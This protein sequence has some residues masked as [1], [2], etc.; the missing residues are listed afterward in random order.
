MD[1]SIEKS[2]E[3]RITK[4]FDLNL[5]YS[6]T[7]DLKDW[8]MSEL[9]IPNTYK[10]EINKSD[11][12]AVFGIILPI[13]ISTSVLTFKTI[14]QYFKWK[15]LDTERKSKNIEIE[16]Q[17]QIK[18]KELDNEGKKLDNEN[19]VKLKQMEYELKQL[20]YQSQ[21]KLKELDNEGKKLDKDSHQ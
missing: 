2:I 6:L 14:N 21:I 12:L 3:K 10:N 19:N 7:K 13:T 18:L 16:Y 1:K 11:L 20:E 9:N 15:S 8:I 17:S 4:Y 5:L